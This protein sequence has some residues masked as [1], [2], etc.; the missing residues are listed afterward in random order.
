MKRAD[1]ANA[2]ERR[3][4]QIQLDLEQAYALIAELN[5]EQ[6]DLEVLKR[7]YPIEESEIHAPMEDGGFR[8]RD[9]LRKQSTPEIEEAVSEILRANNNQGM[10]L[11]AIYSSLL[12]DGFHI[13]GKNPEL[14]LSAH[15]SNSG[16]FVSDRKLGWRLRD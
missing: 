15:L 14:N 11:S 16:L 9:S 8:A 2:V 3:I 10:K 4:E 6:R 12:E 7:S 5:L 13:R 1:F